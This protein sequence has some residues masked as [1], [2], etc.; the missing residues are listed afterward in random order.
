MLMTRRR[1]LLPVVLSLALG[2]LAPTAAAQVRFHPRVRGALG[3]IP[4]FN[5]EGQAFSPDIATGTSTQV[6]Y[7]GG[8]VMSG[9]VTIHTIFWDGGGTKPFPASP[10]ASASVPS[11]EGLIEQFFTDVAAGSTGISP[12]AGACT[13]ATQSDCNEFTVLP[14]YAEQTGSGAV[15]TGS[16]SISYDDTNPFQ[17][18]LD[19]DAYPSVSLQCAS[20]N[21]APVCITDGQIQTE[22]DKLAPSNERGLHDIWFVFLPPG[23]DE[24]ID[25]GVCGTTAYAAYHSHFDI[26]SHGDTIY[27][28]AVD[29]VIEAGPITAGSDPQGNPDAEATAQAA[30]HETVEAITDPQGAGWM[31]P[32]GFEVA[33]KCE[34]GPQIGTV[35]GNTGP[36]H[37]EYSQVI[38]GHDYLAQDMWSNADHACVQA[39]TQASNTL[40]LPRVQLT[41]FSPVVTGNIGSSTSNVGVAVHLLRA[42]ADGNP[43][44]VAQ[45]VGITDS[46]GAW[47]VTLQHPVGDDRDEIDVDYAGPG[48]PTPFHQ[49][50]LTGNGGNPFNQSGWT[51]W[52]A[53]D[54]GTALAGRTLQIAP[55]SQT[56]VLTATVGGVAVSPPAGDDGLVDECGT[57]TEVAPVPLAGTVGASQVVTVSS[58][59]NRA[60]QDPNL[61]ATPNQAGA[62]V[63]LTV[64]VGEPDS[65]SAF[66]SPLAALFTPGGFPTCTADLEVQS[67]SCQG[68]VPS[69]EYAIT[70][71]SSHQ[72]V[73]ADDTG[74]AR[75][76]LPIQGGDTVTLSNGSQTLSTLQVAN[77]RVDITGEQSV[78]AGGTCQ[79]DNYYAAPLRAVPTSSVA[80]APTSVAGGAALTG[81]ICPSNGDATG[82]PSS[83]IIQ[84]DETSG[85][86]TQ[87][88]VPDIEDTSPMQGET[89]YG[90]FTAL[91]ETGLP[92]PDNTVVP[93]DDSSLVSLSIAHSSGGS[94]VFQSTNVDTVN[95]VP[96]TGLTPGTYTATWTLSD[97][98]GDTRTVT[99]RFVEQPA[100][101]GSPGPQ[102]NTGPQGSQG[103]TG[104]Q[105]PQGKTGPQGRKTG[106]PGP[107]PKVSCTLQKHS[108][109]KCTVTFK[110]AH[111]TKGKLQVRITRG[112]RVAALGKAK[113][114]RGRV[115]LTLREIRH[116]TRGRWTITLVLTRS[117]QRPLTTTLRLRVP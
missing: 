37:A 65:V 83:P 6:T 67:V 97:A 116:L 28:V 79:P 110:P 61:S 80:G 69:Q 72:H 103:K 112:A 90:A 88:E 51:G 45:A 48:A 20:P 47:S 105:G 63:S 111:N 35:L 15:S 91:A 38:G 41:Q 60:F 109:I 1:E 19:H 23:V 14:Q 12:A 52:T 40:P 30:G 34:F 3:L 24:C 2:A 71:A 64:P 107:T 44:Q 86:A 98:N 31:D 96:V 78:L 113:V 76:V 18:I 8:P 53:L 59:D 94:P 9:G 70:D 73:L 4:P 62:L 29:P 16:Y 95:G 100:I 81:M 84:T 50:I 68:L 43:V 22:I 33:D 36:D 54:N 75:A 13:T 57:A 115:T 82:L 55:C 58:S 102:G 56:G 7:H 42:G 74:T 32:N 89:L 46:S 87:T 117:H 114:N 66:A 92:G 17:L 10:N 101:Q 108:K 99:T 25:P 106:P 39:T 5:R 26:N 93:T 21:N 49:V 77:L 85:G 27:A 104:P 11:Y